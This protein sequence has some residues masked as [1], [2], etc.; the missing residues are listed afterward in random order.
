[1]GQIHDGLP[2]SFTVDA[3][4]GETFH[5]TVCE[6]RLNATSTSNVVTY[7]VVVATD[8]S[9]MKLLPYLTANIQFEIEKRPAVLQVP[10]AAL[11][12]KPRPA[13]IA[14]DI[15]KEALAPHVHKAKNGAEGKEAVA[16]DKPED[17]EASKEA[18]AAKGREVARK[19]V[20][21]RTKKNAGR[22]AAL[23]GKNGET[24]AKGQPGKAAD[25]TP[26][27][28]AVRV[29]KGERQRIW[30]KDGPYVR[31]V[32][33]RTG[34]TD[35]SNTEIIPIAVHNRAAGDG[36]TEGISKKVEEGM[37]VVVG[38]NVSADADDTT[39]PFAPKIFKGPG[40]GAPK[41]R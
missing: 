13:Q 8:N 22:L 15:R 35:G 24:I 7:T 1:M 23:T 17:Q 11:R 4:S 9:N 39:N 3:L 40:G 31:P 10:N 28:A 38:E 30:V 36:N 21:D 16:Q 6:I 41:S 19:A 5:G 14:P 33:V 27:P 20:E 26:K 32:D 37:E 2:V 34:I 12:W 18:A 29:S 25:G